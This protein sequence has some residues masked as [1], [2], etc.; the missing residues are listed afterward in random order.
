MNF[1]VR[2]LCFALGCERYKKLSLIPR[3]NRNLKSK[4]QSVGSPR[5]VAIVSFIEKYARIVLK[6]M[7][8][9]CGE[10]ALNQTLYKG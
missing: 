7:V 4:S 2:R 5:R 6:A 3:L 8:L 9:I 1:Q 10:G